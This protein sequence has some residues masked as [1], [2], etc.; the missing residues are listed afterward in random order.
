MNKL[1]M[2]MSMSMNY[3]ELICLFVVDSRKL[4]ICDNTAEYGGFVLSATICG[5]HRFC[6]L[7]CSML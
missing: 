5:T 6:V 7:R 3:M 2:S 1:S 4:N